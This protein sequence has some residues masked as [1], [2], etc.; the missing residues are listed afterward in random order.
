MIHLTVPDSNYWMLL[1]IKPL[2]HIMIIREPFKCYIVQWGGG[3]GGGGCQVSRNKFNE[4]LLVLEGGCWM[5]GCQIPRKKALHDTLIAPY[6]AFTFLPICINLAYIE[7]YCEMSYKAPWPQ[8]PTYPC[9]FTT[10]MQFNGDKKP[11]I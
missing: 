10:L 11:M 5:G 7:D 3:G 4:M 6:L 9:I 2:C 1:H 8:S